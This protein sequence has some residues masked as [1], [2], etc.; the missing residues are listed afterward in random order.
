MTN[1]FPLQFGYFLAPDA[2]DLN[3][4]IFV[5]SIPPP[6]IQYPTLQHSPERFRHLE[7]HHEVIRVP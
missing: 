5:A 7:I 6:L 4:T 3:E 2:A 1:R